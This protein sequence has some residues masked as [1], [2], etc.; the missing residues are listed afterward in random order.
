MTAEGIRLLP[1]R[2][3]LHLIALYL[4]PEGSGSKYSLSGCVESC[5]I[6]IAM[7]VIALLLSSVRLGVERPIT[8]AA[9]LDTFVSL[10]RFLTESI[11]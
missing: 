7:R 3:L 4:R 11:L 6:E 8:F 10:L 5:S 1:K 9:I 2:A